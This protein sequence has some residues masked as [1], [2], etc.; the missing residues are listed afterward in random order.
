MRTIRFIVPSV[1]LVSLVISGCSTVGGDVQAG[2]NALQTG[3]PNDALGYLAP[4][5]EVDPNYKIP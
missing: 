1:F 4:A 5:A 3:R 2:R